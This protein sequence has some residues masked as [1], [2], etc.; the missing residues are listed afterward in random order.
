MTSG[1][2]SVT[3]SITGLPSAAFLDDEASEGQR[4]DTPRPLLSEVQA[5]RTRFID[6]RRDECS[7]SHKQDLIQRWHNS[8]SRRIT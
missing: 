7:Y 4:G 8:E 6:L 2:W 1:R 3:T 5:I